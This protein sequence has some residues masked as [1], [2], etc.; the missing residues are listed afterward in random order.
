MLIAKLQHRN[1]VRLIG[2]GI[3]GEEKML[4]YEYMANKSLDY[5]LFGMYL[6]F[7]SNKIPDI[8]RNKWESMYLVTYHLT[9][10]TKSMLLDW[11][12]RYHI[13]EGIARGLLYLQ[14]DSRYRIIHRDLK[15]ENILLDKDMTP[16]ISDFG[17]ARMFGS[18]DTEINTGRLAGTR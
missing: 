10:R 15:P 8:S 17:L 1:L 16:K 9:D 13:I 5:F 2:C 7:C 6:T 4:I 14:Q 3:S 11:Q 12:T 18:E